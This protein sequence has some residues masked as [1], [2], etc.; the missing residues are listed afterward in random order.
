MR[1]TLAAKRAEVWGKPIGHSLSPVLHTAAYEVLGWD[2]TYERREVS[3]EQL[4]EAL[5]DVDGSW[6][7]VSL[8]MPLKERIL[9]LV[10]QHSAL[11]HELGSANTVFWQAGEL[12]LENT[13][14][15]GVTEALASHGITQLQR[16]LVLGGGATA[17]SVLRALRTA[18]VSSVTLCSRDFQ[19]SHRTYEFAKSLGCEVLWRPLEEASAV[20]DV[21][22]VV[23]SLPAGSAIPPFDTQLRERAV[24]FDVVYDPWPTPL[25]V[26]WSE[27]GGRTIS[28][29]SMLVHQ[30]LG[31]IRL[32]HHQDASSAIPHEE[33]VLEA[34]WEAVSQ[35]RA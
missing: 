30:A 15:W 7:G 32:F 2:A 16:A 21:D 33:T 19:R 12:A 23:S 35:H 10:G 22:I 5:R 31:Q 11:V 20:L 34:M 29:L 17:R 27:A 1:T 13:D 18:G 6:L 25:A 9:P 28:G 3:E 24:L 26:S 14:V 8:T 4:E